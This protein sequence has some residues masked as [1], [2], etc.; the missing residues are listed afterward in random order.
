MAILF[1]CEEL[2][3]GYVIEGPSSSSYK[4]LDLERISLLKQAFFAKFRIE[5][6]NEETEW[7]EML[8]V[9]KR[10]CS[11]SRKARKPTNAGTNDS[12]DTHSE[13]DE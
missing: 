3:E 4:P 12:D 9:A 8:L 1:S 6:Q 11:D 7:N 5:P 13:A 10:K 2:K